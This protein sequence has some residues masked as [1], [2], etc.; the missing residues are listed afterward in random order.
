MT[1]G[2][3]KPQTPTKPSKFS[4]RGVEIFASGNHRGKEYTDSDLDDMVRNFKRFSTGAKPLVRV[5]AVLGHEETQEFLERSDLPSAGWPAR[6][7]RDGATLKA[8]FGD[9][10]PSVARLLKGR[11]YRTVSAEVYDEPPEGVPGS[12][13]MLRRIAFLGGDIPQIKTLADIPVPAEHY[14]ERGPDGKLC[15]LTFRSRAPHRGAFTLFFEASPM[16]RAAMLAELGKLGMDTAA[17]TD[18]VPDAVLGEML[19]IANAGKAAPEPD[20]AMDDE[21]PEAKKKPEEESTDMDDTEAPPMPTDKDTA[22]TYLEH[23]RKMAD[24][25]GCH[26]DA[27]TPPTMAPAAAAAYAERLA[28]LEKRIVEADA[29][30]AKTEKYTERA[31]RAARRAAVEGEVT[32]LVS[33]GKVLPS[34]VDGGLVEDLLDLDD[35]KVRKYS[36]N[37]KTVSLTQLDR[38]MNRLK[39]RPKLMHFGERVK[40][41]KGGSTEDAEVAKV[42]EHYSAFREQ[43]A[44][45]GTTEE[46]LVKAFKS[47]RKNEADLT[48]EAYLGV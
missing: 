38:H 5:P 10:P 26:D 37:G 27:S 23:A 18:A 36:D 47:A 19:R 14:A 17:I 32:V 33:A 8:D 15:T 30:A 29:K 9:L 25:F 13:K 3:A 40:G 11:A 4:L 34:E 41:G 28:R 6:V 48:A 22:K 31:S 16:D 44:K 42:K 2:P 46:G 1:I 43:F 7:Y 20:A 35:T 45:H 24:R 39:G 12:G 21:D